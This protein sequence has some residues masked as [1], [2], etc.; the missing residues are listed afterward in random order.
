MN[1]E[2]CQTDKIYLYYLGMYKKSLEQRNTLLKECY[3]KSEMEDLLDVWD[4]E[5]VQYGKKIIE[6]REEFVKKLQKTA[7]EI[8]L[9]ITGGKED[10]NVIY[11]KNIEIDEYAE[12]LKKS[13][14]RDIRFG[15]THVGPHRD[16]LCFVTGDI[17]M[18][19][20]GSQGQQR[21]CALS[22]KLSE[23]EM[24]KDVTGEVPIL[25]LDDVLSELDTDRQEYL[26]K[27]I[28]DIQTIMTCTGMD[29]FIKNRLEIDK[30][31]KVE[32]G[33]VKEENSF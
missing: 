26:L 2:L 5:I 12:A 22:I 19:K 27:H 10:L 11:E 15:Q 4:D 8:H 20:F 32:N 9:S 6:I 21:T 3:G 17:D 28:H 25:L 14:L 29:D 30:I 13:R 7:R 1:S 31:Y 24:V 33:A 16:D 18:R 23:I